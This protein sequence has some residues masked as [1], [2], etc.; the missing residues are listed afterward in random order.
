[1]I[2]GL[3]LHS[4]LRQAAKVS[5]DP[6]DCFMLLGAEKGDF[7]Q[8]VQ[9]LFH[10]FEHLMMENEMIREDRQALIEFPDTAALYRRNQEIIAEL[11]DVCSR[12]FPKT[13]YNFGLCFL[14][15]YYFQR[16]IAR[17]SPRKRSDYL[18]DSD[19]YLS[20]VNQRGSQEQIVVLLTGSKDRTNIH[21]TAIMV[22]EDLAA[23]MNRCLRKAGTSFRSLSGKIK[24]TEGERT[25]TFLRGISGTGKSVFLKTFAENEK[26]CRYYADPSLFGEDELA[27]LISDV[28]NENG[29]RQFFILLDE[30]RTLTWLQKFELRDTL[31]A[32]PSDITLN[33]VCAVRDDGKNNLSGL[34]PDG[35][36]VRQVEMPLMNQE[37]IRELYEWGSSGLDSGKVLASTCG[38]PPLV[39]S[40]IRNHSE[41]VS[42]WNYWKTLSALFEVRLAS[43]DL[44]L[45]LAVLLSENG[46]IPVSMDTCTNDL[47]N[48]AK[49]EQ[50][51]NYDLCNFLLEHS[52]NGLVSQSEDGKCW[53]L[54]P[55]VRFLFSKA[56][57][58]INPDES[59]SS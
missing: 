29:S 59:I 8:A 39:R 54:D 41:T 2:T 32:V 42:T 24:E 57:E 10:S 16:I 37:T 19:K 38:Y 33:L 6:R 55:V 27:H 53:V 44:K 46:K 25:F 40:C 26:N 1:M 30:F 22:C 35:Y 5:S 34:I 15:L 51:E 18:A 21:K 50:F 48:N 13:D 12:L 36:Q 14:Y 17:I 23:L 58:F 11:R 7:Q 56:A 52:K 3:S 28:P 49:S 47:R 20:T 45:K 9:A 43:D 31:S 4:F